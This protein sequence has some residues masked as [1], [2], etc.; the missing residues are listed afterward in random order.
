MYGYQL[1]IEQVGQPSA[2]C[3]QQEGSAVSNYFRCEDGVCRPGV[4]NAETQAYESACLSYFGCGLLKPYQ[5]PNGACVKE[6]TECQSHTTNCGSSELAPYQC[7]D[8]TC[9][10]SPQECPQNPALITPISVEFTLNPLAPATIN[11]AFM[12]QV[13]IARLVLPSDSITVGEE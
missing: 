1:E 5:C 10:A 2:I 12:D 8:L 11:F 13:P 3:Q 7:K 6:I 4:F 9:V